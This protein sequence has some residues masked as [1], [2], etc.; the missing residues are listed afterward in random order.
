[1]DEIAEQFLR[2]ALRHKALQFGSFALKS[3][4][5]SPYFFNTGV[6][7]DANALAQLGHF[8]AHAIVRDALAFDVLFGTAYKG[9]PLVCATALSLHREF[10]VNK[11]FAYNR[12]EVKTHGEGG[13]IVG[14]PLHGRVLIID[15][16]ISAGTAAR[17]AVA[18]IRDAGAQPAA[19][20]ISFDRREKGSGA[21]SA[22]RELWRRFGVRVLSVADATQLAE[23]LK[24]DP[25]Y[26]SALE[27]FRSYR[28]RY[29]APS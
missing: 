16:V 6:F 18:T 19:V 15:D 7:D 3:G 13:R 2:F 25:A 21:T 20:V 10:G 11:P 23:I 1:M 12:K 24:A 8:Y 26:A 17:E 9:I 4:R 14:A 22:A 28:K 5:I 27:D 29:A